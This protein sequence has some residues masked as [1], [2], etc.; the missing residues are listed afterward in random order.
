MDPIEKLASLFEHFPG[1][2]PR[3]ANRFVQY[4]LG[5]KSA[6]RTELASMIKELGAHTGQCTSCFR[7][8]VKSNQDHKQCGICASASRDRTL[9][10]I[11]EK[12]SDIANVERSGF[13]GIY[14]VL[15]GTIPLAAETPEKYVR[16]QPLIEHIEKSAAQLKE[17]I[18]GLSATKESDHTRLILTEKLRPLI[19]KYGIRLS[20]LGRGLSTGSELEYADPETIAYAVQARNEAD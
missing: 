16:I 14:F 4:L 5:Q 8:Y 11:V 18:L 15:G 9:L 17:V 1:I 10:F 7:W 12:D 3:Q 13:Q 20:S 19:Q 2:G 6:F